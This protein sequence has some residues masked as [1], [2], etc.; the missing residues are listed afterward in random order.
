MTEPSETAILVVDDD[1]PIRRLAVRMLGIHGY[2]CSEATSEATALEAVAA[3]PPALV[4]TDLAMPGGS[5][6]SLVRRLRATHPDVAAVMITG[7]DDTETAR[8]ALASG[9]YGYVIK[10]FEMNELLIAVAGALTRRSLALENRAHRDRLEE[11]VRR[12]TRDLDESR[13]ETVERLAR[14]V[15]S[16]DPDTGQHLERMSGLVFRLAR[17]LGWSDEH[18]NTL[19]LASILH[20][21]GKVAVPDEILLKR[22]PLSADERAV[23]ETHV[24]IGHGILAGANSELLQLADT[25]A[26]THHERF[27]G[28]GY[29]RGL[30]GEEI[31]LAGRIA[32]VADVFD[33]LA[34]DRPYHRALPER[35]ALEI[36][37]ADRGL[38]PAVVAALDAILGRHGPRQMGDS[39]HLVS[40]EGMDVTPREP[41]MRARS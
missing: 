41:P 25:V 37:R 1:A 34:S 21:V 8:A 12:R 38:D 13:A 17:N 28:S 9:A 40:A 36:I 6:I 7:R 22:G 26:W 11:L 4:L 23:I 2:R 14:A 29:P 19:R 33:A 39:E 24:P 30:S 18:A 27:D 31:P 35:E 15:E 5:G 3:S 32:A 10:P 16:R 20:D